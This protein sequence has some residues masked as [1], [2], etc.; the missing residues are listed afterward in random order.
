VKAYPSTAAIG[1]TVDLAVVSVPAAVVREAVRSCAEAG[2]RGL[3]VVSAGYAETGEQGKRRQED[4]LAF[5]REHGM[6]MVGPNCLGLM[7]THPDVRMNASFSPV[8][9]PHGAVGLCSQSGAMG[10]AVVARARRLGLGLSTFV[11][12]GNKADVA[13]DDLLEYWEEDPSTEV[14]LFYL[15]SFERPRRFARVARRVA[16]SKPVVVVKAGRSEAGERA[17]GSHTAALS[18]SDTAVEAL[19][20]QTGIV[21]AATLQEMFGIARAVTDQP[22]PPGRRFAV[23]TNSGGPAILCADALEGAGLRVEPLS[24]ETRDA[25]RAFLPPEAAVGNPVDMIASADPE[26]YRR[27]VEAVLSAPEVDGL[28]VIYTPV[29][30]HDTGDVEDAVMEGV[31][32]AREA[33]AGAKPVYASVVGGE[34]DVLVL[35]GGEDGPT[36]PAFPFPEEIGRVAGKLAAYAEWRSEEPGAFP[37]FPDQ[38]L[39]RAR[40]VCREAL[41]ERGGGW[42]TVT[43]A[44]RVL[45]LAG[46][47]TSEG[48]VAAGPE[49]AVEVADGVGYPV[50]VK[51]ASTEIVHKTDLG[52]VKLDLAGPEEVRRAV[53]DIEGTLEAEGR[54]GAMQGVLV[55]PMLSGTAEIMMG[56]S[57]DPA[58]GPVLAFGMGGIHVEIL[59][60]VAF[61]VCPLTDTD[62]R[63][64]VREI[65]GYRLL[66]GYRGHPAADVEALEEALLRLSRLVEAVEEL[67]ELDMNPV[68]ALQPGE[69]YRVADARIRIAGG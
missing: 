17:A 57:Q 26:G 35:S 1:E 39:D 28:V 59:R 18:A 52:A 27:A 56:M 24:E 4:L 6:R 62:A 67:E 55:Q 61:R 51:L 14:L 22:L 64:M 13:A 5:A 47:H 11:S 21:R 34:E 33:G 69:G 20:R 3:V 38:A 30:V 15:E 7:H 68:F 19:F 31:R 58:F 66:E 29:G 10:I 60:D 2:V 44:R 50:A 53:R 65:R 54:L 46:L 49:E 45:E 25:L 40:A 48:A 42:L 8:M 43:E 41:E 16:R 37:E 32:A 63:R 36:V 12:V 9:P 23:V